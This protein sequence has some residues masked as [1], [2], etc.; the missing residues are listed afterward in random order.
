VRITT[1]T[2][3]DK[4]WI[5][6]A[7]TGPG[8]AAERLHR[9]FDPFYTTKENSSGLG[10]S[11]AYGIIKEHGGELTVASTPGHGTT[12]TIALPLLV[13]GRLGKIKQRIGKIK[14]IFSSV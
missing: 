9:I 4:L 8:I 2:G 5:E 12:F 14:H 13:S 7:D 6:I 11:L 1:A 10:L 3:H